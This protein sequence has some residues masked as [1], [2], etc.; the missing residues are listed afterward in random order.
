MISDYMY[1]SRMER[2]IISVNNSESVTAASGVG[3]LGTL[4]SG[5]LGITRTYYHY[6]R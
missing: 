6:F 5:K 3:T 2:G 1:L 4:T